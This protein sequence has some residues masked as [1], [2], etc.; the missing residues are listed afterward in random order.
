MVGATAADDAAVYLLTPDRALVATVD[1]FTPIVDDPAAFG[2][3]AAANSRS[4]VYAMGATPLFALSLIGFPR[5]L[6][7]SGLLEQIVAGGAAK[8]AEAGV[9]VVGRHS[10]DDAEPRN[11]HAQTGE[12]PRE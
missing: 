9:P 8:L 10:I 5:Q 2:A 6:L 12:D 4:D 7:G 1:F 11:A 3:I